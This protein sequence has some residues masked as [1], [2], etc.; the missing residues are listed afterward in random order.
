M[1]ERTVSSTAPRPG[2]PRILF[3]SHDSF[4]LGHLRRTLTLAEA[5]RPRLPDAQILL[6]TGSPCATHFEA[7]SGIDVIKLPSVTKNASGEYVPRT[8]GGELDPLLRLRRQ[9]LTEIHRT[10]APDLLVVDHQVLGL[11]DELSEV[12]RDARTLGTRTILGVR[13]II[14]AP[15]TVAREWGRPRA[16]RALAEEYDR[17]CV[18]GSPDVFDT[19]REYPIPPELEARVEFVGYIAR[20]ARAAPRAARAA[21]TAQ[22]HVLV[23]VGGGEDGEGRI[24]TYLEALELAP[25]P[26]RTTIVLGPLADAARARVFKRRARALPGVKLQRFHADIPHLLTECDA[27]VSMAG[28]NS[29]VEILQSRVPSVLCPRSFPRREQLMR[30]ERLA[31]LG[32]ANCLPAPTPERL[33]AAVERALA[34]GPVRATL[35]PLDGAERL[36]EVALELLAERHAVS[37]RTVSQ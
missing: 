17:V 26:W 12:L 29:V 3:H 23:T 28:Y 21:R 14:D 6:T 5:L 31:A 11:C 10:F 22:K 15:E 35:P 7:R 2:A 4:G 30:A 33:R 25:V 20:P 19:R 36:C 9:M 24:E 8:L 27:V 1:F 37:A 34:S 13:D 32:L 16:R 18:Y